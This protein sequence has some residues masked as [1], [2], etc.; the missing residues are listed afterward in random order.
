M[1]WRGALFH[2]FLLAL[3]DEDA[4]VR[5]LAEYLLTDSLA[6]KVRHKGNVSRLCLEDHPDPPPLLPSK[7]LP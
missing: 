3:V 1:K 4:G 5:D 6:S 2:H 7:L